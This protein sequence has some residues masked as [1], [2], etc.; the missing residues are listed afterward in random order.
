ML[1][2]ARRNR[3]E[4]WTGEAG[5]AFEARL[6][7]LIDQ[8]ADVRGDLRRA[9]TQLEAFATGLDFAQELM[10]RVRDD[11]L[12]AGLAV[13]E[14][15]VLPPEQ[16]RTLVGPVGPPAV[17]ALQDRYVECAETAA[18]ARRVEDAAHE[19]IQ[20]VLADLCAAP[21]WEEWLR[22]AGVL[23]PEAP[24]SW[25]TAEGAGPGGPSARHRMGDRIKERSI[26]STACP[27][28]GGCSA[29]LPPASPSPGNSG[30]RSATAAVSR[31]RS[32]APPWTG[33]PS[34]TPPPPSRRAGLCTSRRPTSDR[35]ASLRDRPRR[36]GT[37]GGP[38]P[39]AP[40]R[41]SWGCPR[42]PPRRSRAPTCESA[43]ASLPPT[44]A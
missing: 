11:A 10:R 18:W 39:T 17:S 26:L 12:A 20:G 28:H 15:R 8:V 33:T 29:T 22:K 36:R 25:P 27:A 5:D 3:S 24:P 4:A 13:V 32:P 43:S 16:G 41:P 34:P 38:R 23:P 44:P 35:P 19:N 2:W 37:G 7:W 6:T 14:E 21:L 1:A 31:S 42:A 30:R 9:Q 40:G